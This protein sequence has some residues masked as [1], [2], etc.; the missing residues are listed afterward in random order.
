MAG[1]V[2][3]TPK[4]TWPMA[5]ATLWVMGLEEMEI[6]WMVELGVR[7]GRGGE[8]G[9]G[10][11]RVVE[12]QRMW[13]GAG[14]SDGRRWY[15]VLVCAEE[16]GGVLMRQAG[17]VRREGMGVTIDGATCE[18]ANGSVG[19]STAGGAGSVKRFVKRFVKSLIGWC[20]RVLSGEL[21][22]VWHDIVR[23]MISYPV[24]PRDGKR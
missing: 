14:G 2:D 4:R 6:W 18:D 24:C 3:R 22:W 5:R 20:A 15:G 21:N 7:W 23:F 8:S 12:K 11:V 1:R 19:S 17:L 16:V 9:A 13:D 10:R